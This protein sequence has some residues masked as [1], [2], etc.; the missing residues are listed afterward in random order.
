MPLYFLT[1]SWVI[2][3]V[4]RHRRL[5]L[6]LVFPVVWTA[7][8]FLRAHGPLAFPWFLLGHTQIRLLSMI[9]IADLGGTYIVSF[10]VAMTNGWLADRIIYSIQHRK[11]PSLSLPRR[12]PVGATVLVTVLG[13]TILY[14]WYRLNYRHT[15]PGPIV[16]VVQGDFLLQPEEL[17]Q[18]KNGKSLNV[19]KREKFIS[20]LD[21]A[22][23]SDPEPELVV[24]PE[25]PWA[26]TLNREYFEYY[27]SLEE[28][29]TGIAKE[30]AKKRTKNIRRH[31][32]LI[33]QRVNTYDTSLVI[34][35]QS[36]E[37][38]PR[39]S[40]HKYRIYNSAFFYRPGI[41]GNERYDKIHLVPFGEVVPFY[42][43]E[44]FQWLYRL[45]NDGPWN[46]W[47]G[48][49]AGNFQWP[50]FPLKDWKPFGEGGFDY[51]CTYG[52]EYK[53]FHLDSLVSKAQPARFGVT[54]CYED[55]MPQ[56]FREFILDEKNHKRIDFMLNISNDGWFGHG[57]QQAQ[58]LV[59]CAFRAVENRVPVARSVNTGI[60]G[61]VETDGSWR[62]IITGRTGR[63]DAG[64]EGYRTA[65]L[66]L[67]G[68]TTFYSRHG[69]LFAILC[70]IWAAGG[71]AD[72]LIAWSAHRRLVRRNATKQR[73]T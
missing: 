70:L 17:V 55:V 40:K 28:K 33:S 59:S 46:P 42:E 6:V 61:F 38:M 51:S 32:D 71:A 9:Q 25:T 73:A 64:G 53:V 10:A 63:L 35:A 26:L 49:R 5:P 39:G 62:S 56:V 44:R 43:S 27:E 2:R 47:G 23:R 14:G 37:F 3:H 20:L 11:D 67:D 22:A 29:A 21:E 4:Y 66:Q 65:Q 58:H 72:A 24:L 1:P 12:I 57:R 30:R 50:S 18:P 13:L 41:E 16:S 7:L 15:V 45:L 69:D 48:Q 60:S 8:E 34:G 54:I 31:H 68:R 36:F 19:I 52:K